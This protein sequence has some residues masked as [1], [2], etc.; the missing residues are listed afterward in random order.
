MGIIVW[1]L[2]YYKNYYKRDIMAPR[3]SDTVHF[4]LRRNDSLHFAQ[5]AFCR[6]MAVINL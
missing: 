1:E 4:A 3:Q 5:I 6:I 2:L